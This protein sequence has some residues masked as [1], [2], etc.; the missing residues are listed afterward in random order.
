MKL[1]LEI[2]YKHNQSIEILANDN[3]DSYFLKKDIDP[4]DNY[5]E[6]LAESI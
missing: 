5:W 4:C 3:P 6:D 1:D 2:H